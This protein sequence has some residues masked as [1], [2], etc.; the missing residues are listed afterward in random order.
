MIW[1][2][3]VNLIVRGHTGH[4]RDVLTPNALD[5]YQGGV[6]GELAAWALG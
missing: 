4:F 3:R 1:G 2:P 5:R 6:L